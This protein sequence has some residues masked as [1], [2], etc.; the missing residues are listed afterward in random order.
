VGAVALRLPLLRLKMQMLRLFGVEERRA[1]FLK[2]TNDVSD[3]LM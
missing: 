1:V 3:G 2:K